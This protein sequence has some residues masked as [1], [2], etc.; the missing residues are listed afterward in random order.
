MRLRAQIAAS[1]LFVCA[2][3]V[4]ARAQDPVTPRMP[5]YGPGTI[6][7]SATGE[8]SAQPDRAFI[9][10][11]VETQ[12]ATAQAA[13][14]ENARR[15]EQVI[16]AVVRAGVARQDVQ[17]R[18]YSVFPVYEQPAPGRET[19]EP[20]IVGYRV[21][22]TVSAQTDDVRRVGALID[23]ALGAGANRSYGLRFGFRDPSRAQAEALR[24]AI[25][26]ARAE[27]EVI[28]QGLGVTLGRVVDASTASQP[29]AFPVM[30]EARMM[31]DAAAVQTPVEPGRQQ[32]QATITLV[33]QVGAM[34]A[35]P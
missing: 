29:R 34:T 23:A 30:A 13:S 21:T 15:M 22:N 8:A 1:L 33:Y 31:A 7:V 24:D 32:V 5:G 6:R 16:A 27:A 19:V 9:D 14:A 11:G 28:A 26:R 17:T 4:P 3:A 2:A 20:R 35:Q 25:R 10:F 12:A 18:D